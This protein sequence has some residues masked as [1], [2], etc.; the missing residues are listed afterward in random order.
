METRELIFKILRYKDLKA[1]QCP[2][3][4]HQLNNT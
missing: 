3:S 4:L 1:G 2:L